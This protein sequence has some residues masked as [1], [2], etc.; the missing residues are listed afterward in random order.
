MLNF[1]ITKGFLLRSY[2]AHHNSILQFCCCFYDCCFSFTLIH[3]VGLL[4]YRR[5]PR[6]CLYY[7]TSIIVATAA[8]AAAAHIS[9]IVILSPRILF[10][11]FVCLFVLLHF[12]FN[13]Y[14]SY[15]YTNS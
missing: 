3:F 9:F 10:I 14:N 12:N 11:F 15:K 8:A 6:L 7:I 1:P 13:T 4:N 5:F 2:S